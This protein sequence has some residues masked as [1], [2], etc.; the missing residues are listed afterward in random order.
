MIHWND[1][2]TDI[3]FGVFFLV[4]GW[5]LTSL[6]L[7]GIYITIKDRDWI[8]L[9]VILPIT[10]MMLTGLIVYSICAYNYLRNYLEKKE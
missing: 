5:T 9:G 6:C 2:L 10:L 3:S 8:M 4:M 1:K 7:D